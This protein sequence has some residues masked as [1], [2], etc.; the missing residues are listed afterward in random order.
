MTHSF[1]ANPRAIREVEHFWVPMPDGTRLAAKMWLPID[2]EDE[3]VPAIL[4]FL[5]YRKR[6]GTRHRDRVNH[7]PVAEAGYACIRVDIRGTGDSEGVYHD[8]YTPQEQQDGCDIIAWLAE[9][10]WCNG[11]VG[12]IGI[13]WGGF[14]GLQIAAHRPPALK[15]IVS[16]G[17]TDD[18]YATDVHYY[19]GCL[20]KDNI[21]WGAVMF[22]YNGLPPDPELVGENWRAMWQARLEANVPWTLEWLRHQRRDDYWRQGSVCE[23][24]SKI[25]CA[26]YAV[27]GW[28]DNYN[29]AV[30]RLVAG[31]DAPVIGLS[32]P[33]CH[34]YP[35]RGYPG[36]AIGFLQET[37]RWWDHWLK[38]IDTGIMQEPAWR[39]WVQESVPPATSYDERPGHWVGEPSWPSPLTDWKRW[40]MN[41]GRLDRE[42]GAPIPLAVKSLQ[43]TGL[44]QAQL[45]HHGEPG[46]FSSDQREDDAGSLVF[47]SD[48]LDE[49]LQILGAPIVQLTLS[50]DR[51]TAFVAVRLNDVAPDGASTRVHHGVL[52]LTRPTDR[53]VTQPLIT[54][55]PITVRVEID[56]IGHVFAAGH[57][58]AVSVSSTYWPLIWPSPEPVTLTLTAGEC[59]LEL[60]VRPVQ[61]ADTELRAFEEPVNGPGDVM[62]TQ[63]EADI[64]RFITRDPATGLVTEHTQFDDGL[65]LHD[66]IGIIEGALGNSWHSVREGDPLSADSRTER[67][68]TWKKDG[69]E[70]EIH[71]SQRL[72]AD[73]T[74]FFF[75][76]H[77][78][79]F[80][81]GK[82][83]FVREWKE[84]VPRD[85]N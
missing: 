79:A 80:E 78:E 74:D 25:A 30:P 31:L 59:H 37:V 17:S 53:S 84:T 3:P 47:L 8:E 15:A 75:E 82:S 33:W 63:R 6:E 26:V 29:E 50:S 11:A 44:T 46:C 19:G 40:F 71:T 1:A 72:T 12:I 58:I 21:D 52:N 9:Q 77:L 62:T 10:S 45:C 35:N 69:L 39:A 68:D 48:P 65:T 41:P 57:R 66:E 43:T 55:K 14:N 70:I 4:E 34:Q 73:K 54:G 32:G 28:G 76:A 49:A 23:D 42:A 81:N 38:G 56:D 64:K 13:S 16:I 18:R 5:P 24:F 22:G 7:P 36:P 85:G 60:P 20:I 83:V 67:V 27:S 2:A 61:A 51:P